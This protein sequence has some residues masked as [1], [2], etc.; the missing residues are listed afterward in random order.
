MR[1]LFYDAEN[2]EP[3]ARRHA[4]PERSLTNPGSTVAD[5]R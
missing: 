5:N 1:P 3:L 2:G 4:P